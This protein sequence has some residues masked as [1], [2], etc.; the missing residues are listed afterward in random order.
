MATRVLNQ[1]CRAKHGRFGAK[2]GRQRSHLCS[3]TPVPG[4]FYP[5]IPLTD[6]GGAGAVLSPRILSGSA[7]A[8]SPHEHNKIGSVLTESLWLSSG[9]KAS[10][11]GIVQREVTRVVLGAW[12]PSA[13]RV[14]CLPSFPN[15]A[16][17]SDTGKLKK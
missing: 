8:T 4:S 11:G 14:T 10:P 7:S 13:K 5:P 1:L 12:S 3:F 17:N 9:G 15:A 16:R 6:L 2:H